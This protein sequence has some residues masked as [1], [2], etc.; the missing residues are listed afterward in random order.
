MTPVNTVRGDA[1]IGK[2]VRYVNG[3][4]CSSPCR[5]QDGT[6]LGHP[7]GSEYQDLPPGYCLI[8]RDVPGV[9]MA[10]RNRDTPAN[11]S[12]S[13]AMMGRAQMES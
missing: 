1:L 5:Q 6:E 2:R 9:P 11:I 10:T 7:N 8:G 4:S 3:A 13:V 12:P